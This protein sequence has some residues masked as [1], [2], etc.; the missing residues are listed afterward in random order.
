MTSGATGVASSTCVVVVGS[1]VDTRENAGCGG[2]DK[3]YI[4]SAGETIRVTGART[5]ITESI[6]LETLST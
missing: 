6:T 5:A 4:E 1:I 3:V 2:G